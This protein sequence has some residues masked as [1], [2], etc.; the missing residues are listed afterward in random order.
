MSRF[1]STLVWSLVKMR[2]VALVAVVESSRQI[3]CDKG[4]PGLAIFRSLKAND[5]LVPL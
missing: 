3:Q 2:L 4:E 5:V 1:R